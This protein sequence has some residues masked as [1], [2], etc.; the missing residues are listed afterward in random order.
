MTQWKDET[1]RLANLSRI[2]ISADEAE[3]LSRQ[4]SE[5]VS[6][7]EQIKKVSSVSRSISARAITQ[8]NLRPDKAK[9][10]PPGLSRAMLRNLALSYDLKTN[11]VITP[12]VF[13]ENNEL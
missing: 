7:F 4:L 10:G 2:Q 1:A 13:E 5:I 6:F 12:A 3:R 11:Q 8:K 9:S